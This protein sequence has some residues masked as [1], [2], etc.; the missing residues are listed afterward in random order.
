MITPAYSDYQTRDIIHKLAE[1]EDLEEQGLLLRLPCSEGDV[2]WVLEKTL[3]EIC[4][5]PATVTYISPYGT[6]SMDIHGGNTQIWNFCAKADSK[7]VFMSFYDF[8]ESVFL[9]QSKAEEKLEEL[10]DE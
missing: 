2:V 1:Y 7:V 3:N 6:R 8:G 10:K 4:I 9:T 5:F